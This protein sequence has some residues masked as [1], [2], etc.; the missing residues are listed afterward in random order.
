MKYV[1]HSHTSAEEY[2]Y[3]STSLSLRHTSNSRGLRFDRDDTT[4]SLSITTELLRS[5][6]EH[7]PGGGCNEATERNPMDDFARVLW[8]ARTGGFL[9]QRWK[10]PRQ[11]IISLLCAWTV[12]NAALSHFPHD[13]VQSQCALH[14]HGFCRLGCCVH[15]S[16]KNQNKAKKGVLG[17]STCKSKSTERAVPQI[18]WRLA[19]ASKKNLWM[20]WNDLQQFRRALIHYWTQNYL[21][22]YCDEGIYATRRKTG[23]NSKVRTLN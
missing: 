10:K 15:S 12:K 6:S 3:H 5:W 23:S 22:K 14:K 16:V 19:Y 7:R 20:F 11:S 9:P 13:L 4:F 21:P 18:V 2:L 1:W 8:L 17:T